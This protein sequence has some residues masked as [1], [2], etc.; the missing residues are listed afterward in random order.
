M[1][2]PSTPPNITRDMFEAY[3]RI[4]V[5]GQTNMFNVVVVGYL[6]GLSREEIIAIQKSYSSLCNAYPDVRELLS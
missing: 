2:Q 6:S 1:T 3:E 5:S 4:R